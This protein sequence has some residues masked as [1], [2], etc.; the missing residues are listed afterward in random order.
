MQANVTVKVQKKPHTRKAGIVGALVAAATTAKTWIPAAIQGASWLKLS[1][2][3]K[4]GLSMVLFV[5]VYATTYGWAFAAAMVA[6]LFIHEMGHWMWVRANG[7]K[8]EVPIFIPF[9]GAVILLKEIPV[10]QATR[11]WIGYAGPLVGGLGALAFWLLGCAL[12]SGWLMAGGCFGFLLN[13]FQLLP[14]KPLDGGWIVGAIS[15][16]LLIPGTIAI[17]LLAIVAHSPLLILIAI[18]AVTS[19]FSKDLPPTAVPQLPEMTVGEYERELVDGTLEEKKSAAIARAAATTQE[20]PATVRQRWAIGLA[21][22][23]LVA[24]LGYMHGMSHDVMEKRLKVSDP[25]KYLQSQ[26]QK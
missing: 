5:G 7:V 21:Y 8:A 23:G 15:K 13:I 16:W 10:D 25:V 14:T 20:K 11:A 26:A 24:F 17:V 6:L 4:T 18:I 22:L 9:V 19:L 12:D 1:W 3:L 2:V